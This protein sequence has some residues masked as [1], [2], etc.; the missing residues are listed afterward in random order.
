MTY[1]DDEIP[2]HLKGQGVYCNPCFQEQVAPH[3]DEYNQTLERAKEVF[4]FFKEE[5]KET[6]LIR[7]SERSFKVLGDDKE[8]IVL[9]L[10]FLTARAGFNAVVD[11]MVTSEK[12]RDGSYKLL[13]WRGSGT[14]A[15]VDSVKHN[16]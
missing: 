11:I 10:A 16:R 9:K 8:D 4:V 5:S 2:Q 13:T 3:L 1:L 7:R 6:R 15:R 12:R 14:A